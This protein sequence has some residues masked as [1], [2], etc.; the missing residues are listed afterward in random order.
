MA[1][2][3]EVSDIIPATP[4]QVYKAWLDSDGHTNMTGGPA[5]ASTDVGGEF[6]AWDG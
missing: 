6:E 3:F 4:D 5:K 2:E 1:I